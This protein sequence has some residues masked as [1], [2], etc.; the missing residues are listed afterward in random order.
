MSELLAVSFG[1]LLRS[2][3]MAAGLTQEEL[4]EA[5][6]VSYRSISDL[7][8]WVSRYQRRDT[9]RLL[10]NALGLSEDER[11]RFEAVARGRRS[12]PGTVAPRPLSEGIAVATRTLPRQL[13]A[14]TPHFVGRANE[15]AA[16]TSLLDKAVG[17]SR[18]APG[19][20]M[21][22]AIGGPA[23]IGTQPVW[24][25]NTGT[26]PQA[27]DRRELMRNAILSREPTAGCR[28]SPFLSRGTALT[29]AAA[30]CLIDLSSAFS[31]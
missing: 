30:G 26:R 28:F 17:P 3:R 14:H 4:A 21:I 27:P 9:T 16:L 31:H 5:A 20:I 18:L 2:L 6:R 24:P 25:V 7:E 23:G 22:S 15:L 8:R 19:T 11:A 1:S 13:P 29:W 10:A 12:A